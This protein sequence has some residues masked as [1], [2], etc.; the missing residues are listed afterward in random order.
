MKESIAELVIL[1]RIVR[2][3]VWFK[4]GDLTFHSSLRHFCAMEIFKVIR[5][6]ISNSCNCSADRLMKYT[7]NAAY[8][9]R[10][11]FPFSEQR[12]LEQMMPTRQILTITIIKHV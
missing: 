12:T 11:M 4:Q 10:I 2:F 5:N 9:M 6:L 8:V 7:V 3:Q 1:E